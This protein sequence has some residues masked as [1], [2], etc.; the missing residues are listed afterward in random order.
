MIILVS[1]IIVCCVFFKLSKVLN[2]N[3]T[4]FKRKERLRLLER[5]LGF[6]GHKV[7]SN[8]SKQDPKLVK[9]KLA[10]VKSTYFLCFV[11]WH[12]LQF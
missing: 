5:V 12:I 3:N 2:L 8:P 7:N 11:Y 9:I 4:Y 1:I 6:P 10:A